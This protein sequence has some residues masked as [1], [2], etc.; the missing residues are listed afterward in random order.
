[1]KEKVSIL[2][3]NAL[4][5]FMDFGIG[6][7]IA[8]FV[9]QTYGVP[10]PWYLVFLGG[11]LSLVPDFDLVLSV[12]LG[13]SPAFDHHQTP[14]HRPLLVLPIVAVLAYLLG[15]EMWFLITFIC[16]FGHYLHDTNFISTEYGIAWFWPFSQ[17]YW[18]VFGSFTPDPFV[19]GSHYVWLRKNWLRPSCMSLREISIGLVGVSIS[20]WYLALPTPLIAGL[21]FGFIISIIGVW[22]IQNKAS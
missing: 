7:A 15:G 10:L 1:M 13:V 20:L 6:T 3:G 2:A 12:L 5:A 16:V 11:I 21:L 14:F 17:K 9:A 19:S 22:S 18:S 4:A 8:T